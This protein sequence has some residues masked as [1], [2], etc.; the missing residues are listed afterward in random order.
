MTASRLILLTMAKVVEKVRTHF[1]FSDFF[2][3]EN[4][5]VY[6][7]M[8]KIWWNQRGYNMPRCY[9]AC[10]V[11][12]VCTYMP[13]PYSCLSTAKALSCLPFRHY[14]NRMVLVLLVCFPFILRIAVLLRHLLLTQVSS[15]GVS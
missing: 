6:E 2:S 4:R 8:S 7:I 9:V 5:A 10:L 1:M 14:S 11:A 13:F 12:F 15:P 3:F